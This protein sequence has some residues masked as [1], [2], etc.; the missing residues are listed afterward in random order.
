MVDAYYTYNILTCKRGEFRMD[1]VI[2]HHLITRP[3][4]PVSSAI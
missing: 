2:I 4:Y 1:D 3:S